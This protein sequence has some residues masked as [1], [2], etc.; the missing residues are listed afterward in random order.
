MHRQKRAMV[1]I[2]MAG[3][4][5]VLGS[6]AQGLLAHPAAGDVLWGGVPQGIRPFYTAGMLLATAGY[7]AFTHYLFFR[8]KPDET[9]I[10][11]RLGFGVFNGLY[12]A[13]LAPSAVWMPL[14]LS[15]FEHPKA[16]LWW[17]IR[18]VLALVGLTSL[19]MLWALV[20]V[21]PRRPVWAYWLAV[22][23]ILVFCVQTVVLDAL[24][25]PAFWRKGSGL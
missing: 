5:A 23:G 11:K 9:R 19:G 4:A 21:T 24:I 17:A 20:R 1:A 2:N 12:A 8:L 7:F 22:A 13:I 6:Y 10:G 15:I 18:V 3:G 14:T 25:W 16:G